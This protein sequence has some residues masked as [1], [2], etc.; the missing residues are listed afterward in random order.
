MGSGGFAWADLAMKFVESQGGVA[1]GGIS[2]IV[3]D[4]PHPGSRHP[5]F[6]A[7]FGELQASGLQITDSFRPRTHVP[8]NYGIT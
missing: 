4:V 1:P 5:Y 3:G 2:P 8:G 7:D 6:F